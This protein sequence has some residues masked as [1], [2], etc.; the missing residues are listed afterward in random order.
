MDEGIET[1]SRDHLAHPRMASRL[2]VELRPMLTLA[3]PVVVAELGW[4]GMAICDTI[5]VGPLGPEATGAV[6][7]G[8]S[9]YMASAIFGMGL[10]LGLDT[11]VSHDHG[12]GR[13]DEAR[14]SLTQ[15]VYLALG[16]TPVLMLLVWGTIA[17]LPGW[18]I[19]RVVLGET[20][21]YLVAIGWGTGPLLLYAAL[22]RYLQGVDRVGPITFAL[23]SANLVNAGVNWLL[24]SGHWGAP[25]LGVTGSGWATTLSRTYLTLVLMAAYWSYRRSLPVIEPRHWPRFEPARMRRLLILGWPAA[26]QVTMEVGVFATATALAGRL[27]PSDLAAH[28]IALNVS[29]VTF[30]VPLG[31]ASAGAVRVGQALGRKDPRGA[32]TSGWMAILIGLAFMACSGL[33]LLLLARPIIAVFTRDPATTM[34]AVRLFALAAAFQLFDGVQVVATGVLRGAGDTRSAMVTNLVAHWGIGL[35][36][37]Y[38]LGFGLGYGVFG[39][40]AGLSIGLIV[41]GLANLYHWIRAARAIAKGIDG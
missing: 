40:W 17:L 37:G 10:L 16:L 33:G 26:L 6:G 1:L 21:P 34:A 9:L 5:F 36:V 31:V 12:A 23:V 14:R 27:A 41:A 35:P 25:K 38:G 8:S 28:Q 22:R 3:G 39:L 11:M 32:V 29:S 13:E 18:G 15:G 24:I 19:N 4:M 2:A 30:M 7:L 20:V